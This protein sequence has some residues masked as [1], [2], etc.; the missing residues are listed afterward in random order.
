MFSSDNYDYK[1]FGYFSDNISRSLKNWS[2]R[3]SQTDHSKRF[4]DLYS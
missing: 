3:S 2:G 1:Q 4:T